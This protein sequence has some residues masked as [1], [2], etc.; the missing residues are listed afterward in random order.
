MRSAIGDR[1]RSLAAAE[2][3]IV[4]QCLLD[5]LGVTLRGAGDPV[6]RAARAAASSWGGSSTQPGSATVIGTAMKAGP[7]DAALVNGI[8]GHVL[9]YDDTALGPFEGHPS[10]PLLPALL[11]L[12][13]ARE[14]EPARLIEAFAVGHRTGALLGSWV[15]PGHYRRGWH[16]TATL[17]VFSAAAGCAAL[18]GLDADQTGTALALAAA[19]ASGPRASFGTPAKAVQV[20]HA[21]ASGLRCALLA[22][23]GLRVDGDLLEGETGFLAL[24]AGRDDGVAPAGLESIL[25]KY[26]ACCHS[27]HAA[28]EAAA[29]LGL[30]PD[31]VA[32]CE[33]QAALSLIDVC[34]IDDP[35]T[36]LELKFSLRGLTALALL[37]VDT[38]DPDALS[39]RWAQD[40]R[41][42]EVR[43]R[44]RV[45][46][47]DGL[48]DF[49]AQVTVRGGDGASL[50]RFADAGL[51]P[52]PGERWPRLIAKFRRLSAPVIGAG[53]AHSIVEALRALEAQPDL[54]ALLRECAVAP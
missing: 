9:D 39:D 53:R 46:Y 6:P 27:T 19:H 50:T 28:L 29:A 3:T 15:N 32:A 7:A 16:A 20:G 37:G 2:R 52:P 8:A 4:R 21:A 26:H 42:R 23:S 10:A 48:S 38:G 30:D 17:G 43:D 22:E 34:G 45:R 47:V 35:R 40:P 25:V 49:Q 44:V 54:G 1:A 31:E 13:E 11:A 5:W 36:G 51:Q 33:V 12:A 24:H 41:Y 18:L 14:L